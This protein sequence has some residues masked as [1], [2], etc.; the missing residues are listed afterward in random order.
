[1]AIKPVDLQTILARMNEFSKVQAN[2]REHAALL[3]AQQ[4]QST[5]SSEMENDRKII[6]TPENEQATGTKDQESGNQNNDNENRKDKNTTQ[7]DKSKK[8]IPADPDLGKNIDIR[9]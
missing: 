1:M 3:Q 6:E 5:V 4:A 7:T 8:V 2:A 9:G